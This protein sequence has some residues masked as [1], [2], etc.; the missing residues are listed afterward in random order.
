M[1]MRQLCSTNTGRMLMLLWQAH[2]QIMT[3]SSV[4]DQVTGGSRYSESRT[5]FDAILSCKVRQVLGMCHA[6]LHFR[7][8]LCLST[9]H[10]EYCM[11]IYHYGGDL[12]FYLRCWHMCLYSNGIL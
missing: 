7:A 12:C 4:R 6:S 9:C 8:C 1:H 11:P 10:S 3:R 5:S 2:G